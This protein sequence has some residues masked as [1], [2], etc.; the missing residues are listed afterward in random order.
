MYFDCFA[1]AYPLTNGASYF[2]VIDQIKCADS[3]ANHRFHRIAAHASDSE[4]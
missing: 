4:K 1:A 3:R 2:I